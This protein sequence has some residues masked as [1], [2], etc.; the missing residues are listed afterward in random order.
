MSK[1]WQIFAACLLIAYVGWIYWWASSGYIVEG[2][3]CETYEPPKNCESRNV[4]FYSAWAVA[5]ALD[6]WSTL[7]TA[8]ATVVIG[9]FLFTLWSSNRKIL[10]ATNQSINLTAD[11]AKRQLR[12]YVLLDPD[13]PI[14]KLRV[15]V[16]EEPQFVLKMKNFGLTPAY[17]LIVL[18]GSA[19]APWP[20]PDSMDLTIRGPVDGVQI[21][22][23]GGVHFWGS[24]VDAP[25]GN[26]V[27]QEAF[28]SMRVGNIRF[29]IFGRINYL[30]AYDIA[31]YTHFCLVVVP[32]SD[33]NSTDFS[34]QRCHRHNDAN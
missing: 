25:H 4:I 5:K 16:G 7:I 24:S 18:R 13:K 17:K 8:L 27:T 19:F 20:L 1:R 30:D 33:P 11:T 2:P 14:E 22:P 12:A 21:V 31:R 32:P 26:V 15:A 28:N 3:I 10:Q 23:P 9:F 29:Y 34:I 6:H